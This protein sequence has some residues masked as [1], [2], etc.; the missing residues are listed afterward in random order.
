MKIIGQAKKQMQE[1]GVVKK[2][3]IVF[4]TRPKQGAGAGAIRRKTW[5]GKWNVKG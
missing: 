5:G 3:S 2:T 1:Y 4:F